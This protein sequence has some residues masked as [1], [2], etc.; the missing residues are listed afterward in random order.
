MDPRIRAALEAALP[1]LDNPELIDAV[2]EA[3]M[4]GT[5]ILSNQVTNRILL[6]YLHVPHRT[7]EDAVAYILSQGNNAIPL[8][9]QGRADFILEQYAPQGSSG[10]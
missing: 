7:L 1:H 8:I 10:S 5:T 6:I 9:S 3:L 4:R 2:T